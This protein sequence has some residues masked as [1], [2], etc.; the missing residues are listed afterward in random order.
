MD[1]NVIVDN[2]KVFRRTDLEICAPAT[3]ITAVIF[4]RGFISKVFASVNV[5]FGIHPGYHEMAV[6]M[7]DLEIRDDVHIIGWNL[8]FLTEEKQM[9]GETESGT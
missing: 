9:P 3:E 4:L 5:V 8:A 6:A 1:V 2:I 7:P